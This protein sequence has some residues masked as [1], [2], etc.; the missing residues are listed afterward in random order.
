[1]PILIQNARLVTA[2]ADFPGDLYA[3]DDKIT[4]IAPPGSLSPADLPADT[5]VLDGAGKLLMPGFI[6]PHVHIHLPFMGTFAKDDHPTASRAALVGGTTTYLEMVCP[7]RDEEPL[8]AYELWR[9]KAATGVCDYGFHV[10]VTRFDDDVERQ[11][12]ALVAD[13]GQRSFK[14]FLAYKGAFGVTDEEL[15]GV[16]ELAAE[17]GVTVTAHCENAEL[18]ANQQAT[19]V[20]AG[21]VGPGWHEP[22]RPT[23]V[24]AEGVHHFCTFLKMTGATGY[25]VHTSCR[26]AVETVNR[27]R[28]EEVDV[29]IE[30]VIPYL[31]L[32]DTFAQRDASTGH[33]PF[34]GAKYVMSPPIRSRQHREY[35]WSALAAGFIQTVGTDHAPFD[36]ATQ[37]HMGC[38]DPA[39]AVDADFNPTHTASDFTKIPNG[40]PSIE[41][42]AD[43][44]FTGVTDGAITLPQFVAAVSTNAANLF[45]LRT[46]GHLAPGY[47]A[48]LV[49]Y[50]PDAPR[51]ISAQT[52][53]MAT[54][55]SGFEG[56]THPGHAT[57][58]FLRGRPAVA[59][60]RLVDNLPPGQAAPR[61]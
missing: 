21:R 6:D 2:D 34:E 42:R 22:S 37:K 4:T 39:K 45:G 53:H 19:L 58:V 8:E 56:V 27:F 29:A 43:L 11:L 59:D 32:D 41:H 28:G 46:K 61:A 16:C 38:P 48:D 20:R 13:H 57:H 10:G 18:V 60:G 40:I 9:N 12:R 35:L 15:L 50:D 25:V 26:E 47:D 5:A 14:V 30:T 24:E 52:H 23:H 44:L 1:M 33:D 55:Y 36:F 7:S 31:T 54:D 17:L 49:L 51:T 3:A